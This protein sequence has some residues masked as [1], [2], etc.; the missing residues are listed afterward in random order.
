M[1]PRGR[2]V[3]AQAAAVVVVV[4]VIYATLLRPE[5]PTSISVIEA[6]NGG[7]TTAQ[8][9]ARDHHGERRD[10]AFTERRRDG[11]DG[12][13]QGGA[14]AGGL[15]LGVAAGGGAVPP[16]DAGPVLRTPQDDQY[17]DSVKAL[18][19]RVSAHGPPDQ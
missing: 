11:T 4:V 6:P 17:T 9:E 13:A 14:G 18:L 5:D 7:G 3:A 19:D 16:A 10:R 15:S 8:V 2:I 1:N 12:G